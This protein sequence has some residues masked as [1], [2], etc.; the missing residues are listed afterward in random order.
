[1]NYFALKSKI[2]LK[3]LK[4]AYSEIPTLTKVAAQHQLISDY[5]FISANPTQ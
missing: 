5:Y 4:A 1:M 2:Y 3:S